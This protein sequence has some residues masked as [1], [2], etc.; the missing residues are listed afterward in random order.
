MSKAHRLTLAVSLATILVAASSAVMA[1]QPPN[2]NQPPAKKPPQGQA[3][4]PPGPPGAHPGGPPGA[5]PGG[6]LGAPHPAAA[7]F[8]GP[9]GP[10]GPGQFR[11]PAHVAHIGDRGYSFR[12][13]FAG[14]RE[15]V[16]FSPRERAIWIGGRWHH[17]RRFGR[18]GYW[19]EVNGMWYFY[20]QPMEGPP[21]FVSEV[22]FGDDAVD[23]D[24]PVMVGAP[25][26]AVVAPPPAVVVVPAPVVVVP[27]PYVPPPVVCVGPLCVR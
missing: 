6:P 8:R 22:E 23:P 19:W 13:G 20:D 16:T 9:G 27:R 21:A 15:I 11:G 7:Q 26:V 2:P 10:G 14:R 5:H 12:G 1:Q 17:D 4:H 24:A 18:L 3:A 25:P